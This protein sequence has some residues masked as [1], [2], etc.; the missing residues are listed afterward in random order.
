[1]N[2]ESLNGLRGFGAVAVY[3][4]HFFIYFFPTTDEADDVHAP[5]PPPS[6]LKYARN[7]PLVV[8][9]HGYFW[10][11]IF[12]ILS[13]FVLPLSYFKTR[14]L[15]C[16]YGGSLRRYPRLMIPVL[17]SI[18]IYYTVIKFG[19]T[20]EK[21]F[22]RLKRK[23]FGT[24]LLDGLF[25]TWFGN[26]DYTVVTWTLSIELWAS[27]FIYLVA[28]VSIE[29]RWRYIL[30]ILVI[31][32]IWIPLITDSY[33]I[34]NYGLEKH[35]QKFIEHLP[36]FFIGT[37]LCDSE[38]IFKGWR[39]LDAVRRWNI[40]LSILRNTVLLFLF[41]A[42]GSYEGQKACEAVRE[43]NCAFWKAVTFDYAMS[44]DLAG[45]IGA[46]SI[47]LLALVSSS[48]QA[49]LLTSPIQ[50]LGRISYTFYLIHMLFLEWA[51]AD[52]VDLW[53]ANNPDDQFSRNDA[54]LWVFI[55]FT[56]VIIV[57]AWLM[58]KWIDTPSKNLAGEIDQELRV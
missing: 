16:I 20:E 56:P 58:E 11:I 21:A 12:F 3:L 25:G 2:Y 24:L 27:F 23:N 42:Y 26:K 33:L 41:F 38:F 57:I 29:Y 50:F 15:S 9:I 53:L 8:F 22:P 31:L 49:L 19:V 1:M 34:T 36:M 18:S 39:P 52:T 28:F 5:T 45:Y 54:A 14:K 32:F 46:I 6:W 40:W 48:F 55:I 30:Y 17:V 10:V 37:L 13:G 47:I 4:G 7:T 43:G 51:M 44:K 35:Q